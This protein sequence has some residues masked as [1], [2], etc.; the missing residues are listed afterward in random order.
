MAQMT[1]NGTIQATWQMASGLLKAPP[2]LSSGFQFCS[3]PI[4]S[5][6]SHWSDIFLN[7]SVINL[8]ATVIKSHSPSPP[9]PLITKLKLLCL[10]MLRYNPSLV[11]QLHFSQCPPPFPLTSTVLA[12]CVQVRVNSFYFFQQFHVLSHVFLSAQNALP[13]WI[14]LTYRPKASRPQGGL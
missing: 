1:I 13:A 14:S 6:H 3:H 11:F 10:T 9:L 4:Y 8:N 7:A 5:S 12:P 2:T